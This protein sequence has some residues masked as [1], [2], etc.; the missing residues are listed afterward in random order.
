MRL[1]SIPPNP[2]KPKKY[3]IPS[4]RAENLFCQGDEGRNFYIL[5]SGELTVHI[6]GRVL[7]LLGTGASVGELALVKD[8]K[9]SAT[10]QAVGGCILLRISKKSYQRILKG[11]QVISASARACNAAMCCWVC[12]LRWYSSTV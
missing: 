12:L 3:I 4:V 8:D 10:V 7:A 9:R 2:P 1:S 5:L 6:G 11:H